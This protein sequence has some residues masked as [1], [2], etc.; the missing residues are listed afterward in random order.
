ME[1]VAIIVALIGIAWM[2]DWRIR[3]NKKGGR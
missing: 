1:K 3:I 2:N